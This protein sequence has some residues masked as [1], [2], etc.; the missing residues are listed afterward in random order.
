MADLTVCLGADARASMCGAFDSARATIS[1]EFFSISDPEVVASLNRAAARGVRVTVRVDGY[2]HRFRGEHAREPNAD[3]LRG[4]LSANVDV[5]ISRDR[6]RE[7]HGKAAVVD[8]RLSLIATANPR[9]SGFA[10]PG[11]VVV[12][13]RNVDDARAVAR[14]I[15]RGSACSNRIAAGPKGGLRVRLDS[16]L[17][18]PSDLRIA[19]EDLSDPEVVGTLLHRA[20]LGHNDRVLVGNDGSTYS[21]RALADL[22]AGHIDVRRLP[23]KLLHDKFVD[24][25]DAIYTG[26]ANLTRNG[27]EEAREIGIVAPVGDFVDRAASL[28]ADFEAMWAR[29]VPWTHRGG[30]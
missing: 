17:K 3:Q 6:T 25:G 16:L 7:V 11:E 12:F 30:E 5:I 20:H 13:D 22:V 8:R 1:A 19:S 15:A 28:R 27:I 9:P 14:A 2:P 4:G 29:A 21:R 26:S 10:A 24:A 23:G 18:S